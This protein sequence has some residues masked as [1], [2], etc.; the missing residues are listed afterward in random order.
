[1]STIPSVTGEQ[2]AAVDRAMVERLGLDIRQIMETAGRQVAIFARRMLGGDPTG[3]RIVV[4]C[5]TGGN[6]GDGM[7]A[8]R[9][10]A[11]WGAG[12]HV[13]LVSEPDPARH[14]MAAHQLAVLRAMGLPV[15]VDTGIPPADLIIDGLLGFSTRSAPTGT[16]GQLIRAIRTAGSPVLAIDLPSGLHA[17]TGE[18]YDPTVRAISTL[19]LGLPKT[20]LLEQSAA[21]YTGDLWLADIGIPL[22]AYAAAGIDLAPIFARDEFIPLAVDS[23]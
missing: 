13:I 9:Y 4:V 22:A 3:R 6:G 16:V 21:A 20:G 23:E 5:G 17:T 19:T 18:P 12:L 2:M 8:A 1:M 11:G 7:V 14:A 10:L 15:E